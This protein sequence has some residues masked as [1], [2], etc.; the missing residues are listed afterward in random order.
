MASTFQYKANT[1]VRAVVNLNES[2]KEADTTNTADCIQIMTLAADDLSRLVERMLVK[3]DQFRALGMCSMIDVGFHYTKT[4]HLATICTDGLL[5]LKER[6]EK[7]IES[8]NNGSHKGDGTYTCNC[9]VINRNKN[10]GPVGLLVARLK[11]VT[12]KLSQVPGVT[13]VSD[14]LVVLRSSAQCVPLIQFTTAHDDLIRQYQHSIQA[15]IDLRFNTPQPPASTSPL[16]CIDQTIYY[17]APNF[18]NEGTY[19]R[20][21]LEPHGKMPSGEMTVKQRSDV[22]CYGYTPGTIEILYH[23]E[24]GI[25]KMYHW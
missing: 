3:Q 4:E 7:Q 18:L 8:S 19:K 13:Y 5:T 24:A 6:T 20:V 16:V 1:F 15:L 25:Q 10:F 21:A 22:T 17:S 9:H 11:G 12:T 14:S 2:L 23:F